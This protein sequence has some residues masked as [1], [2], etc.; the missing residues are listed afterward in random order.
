M[1]KLFVDFILSD[2]ALDESVFL[3]FDLKRSDFN[4]HETFRHFVAIGIFNEI[5]GGR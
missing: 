1:M 4:E 2:H 3:V 5:F